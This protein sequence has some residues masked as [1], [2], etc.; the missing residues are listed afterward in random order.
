MTTEIW[1][2]IIGLLAAAIAY[3][4]KRI[5]DSTD[6]IADDVADMKPKVKVL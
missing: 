6:G 2:A 3:F 5:I 1:S 4:L